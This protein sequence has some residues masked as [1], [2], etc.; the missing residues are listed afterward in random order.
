MPGKASVSV[1]IGQP[2]GLKY[3][4]PDRIALAVATEG[5]GGGYFSSRLMSIVRAREGL[6]YGIY[7]GLRSDSFGDGLW[8]IQATFAPELLDKGL[9][10]T[11]RELRRFVESGLTTA[12]LENFKGAINGTYKLALATSGGLANQLLVTVQRGLPLDYIDRFPQL[13]QGLT[14]EQVNGA[15]K[16]Y[17]DPDK[18]LTVTAGTLPDAK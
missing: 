2:S 7:A 4:D 9:A 14:L 3:S 8:A 6:T 1:L 17:L 11:R 16:K 15:V 10:S 13:V 18:M 5:F 12:E